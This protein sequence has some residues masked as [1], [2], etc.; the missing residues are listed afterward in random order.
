MP[1]PDRKIPTASRLIPTLV[2]TLLVAA[3]CIG[4]SSALKGEIR[5]DRIILAADHAGSAVRF[6]LHNSGTLACDI[7]LVLTSLKADALPVKDGQVVIS[8]GDGP[9][10]P[11]MTYESQAPY[12]LGHVLPGADFTQEIAMEGAPKA[13]DRVLLCN[14]VGDYEHGRFAPLRFDR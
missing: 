3:G 7:V 14:G 13:E 1:E 11:D 2:A 5:D 10:R 12:T 4:G 8:D 6:E 9:V